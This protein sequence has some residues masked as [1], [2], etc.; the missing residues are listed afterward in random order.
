MAE[1]YEYLVYN[2]RTM[3]EM[4]YSDVFTVCFVRNLRVGVLN[5]K[6]KCL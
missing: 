3:P 2:C 5:L 6:Y 1:L 4:Q